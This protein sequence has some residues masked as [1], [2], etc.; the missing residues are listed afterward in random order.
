MSRPANLHI[1]KLCVGAKTPKDLSDWQ[2]TRPD[3]VH[4]V[5]RMWPKR[6]SEIIGQGSI[7]WVMNGE[8][9]CRQL[10][11]AFQ[12]HRGEDGIRRCKICFDRELVLVAPTPRRAFQGWRYLNASDAPPDIGKIDDAQLPIEIAAELVKLGLT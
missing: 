6:E 8:I 5:T 11:T 10:I 4:H 1:I 3:P 12:E 9:R 7:Y 2:G